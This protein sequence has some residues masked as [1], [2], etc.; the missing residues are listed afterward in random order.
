[1]SPMIRQYSQGKRQ[2]S[3]W[4]T[5][6]AIIL[7]G[8]KSNLAWIEDHGEWCRNMQ[9]YSPPKNLIAK[10]VN[11]HTWFQEIVD[12]ERVEFDLQKNLMEDRYE[13]NHKH[14]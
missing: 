14:F 11:V 10:K 4:V 13:L 7:L 3:H 9:T 1:M 5:S 8:G 6:K 2:H 12:M